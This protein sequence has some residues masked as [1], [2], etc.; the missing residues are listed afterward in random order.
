M[1]LRCKVLKDSC[2]SGPKS[3][4]YYQNWSKIVQVLLKPATHVRDMLANLPLSHD[5]TARM[6]DPKE[7]YDF[8]MSLIF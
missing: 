1:R 6:M 5:G 3:A 7:L 2:H 4:G 8:D